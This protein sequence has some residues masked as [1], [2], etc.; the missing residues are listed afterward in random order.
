MGRAKGHSDYPMMVCYHLFFMFP[1]DIM[2]TGVWS[3]LKEL[4]DM[5]LQRLAEAL[6]SSVLHCKANTTTKK[7]LGA[8]RRWKIWATEHNLQVFPVE[9]VHIALYLQHLAET[10][11][12]KSAVEEAVNGLAWAHSMAESPSPTVSPIVQTRAPLFHGTERNGTE[13]IETLFHVRNG[14]EHIKTNG[15]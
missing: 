4:K 5:D 2:S 13:Q 11:C 7:Y 14:T 9:G 12:S 3:T 15:Y 1:L 10:K 8:F 6:P